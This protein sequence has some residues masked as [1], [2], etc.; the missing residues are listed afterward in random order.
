MKNYLLL[1]LAG[2]LILFS[3]A[4]AVGVNTDIPPNPINT[5]NKQLQEKET[6]LLK[7][8]AE[9]DKQIFIGGGIILALVLLN[10]YL[11]YRH[12]IKDES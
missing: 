1:I 11:D 2:L 4:S 8:E 10:F 9:M 5:L 12:R 7:K 6:K 3:K